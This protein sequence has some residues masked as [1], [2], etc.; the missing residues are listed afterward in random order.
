LLSFAYTHTVI[1]MVSSRKF[2][3]PMIQ[4]LLN[5]VSCSPSLFM[6]EQIRLYDYINNTI[7]TLSADNSPFL[8]ST[9]T[10]VIHGMVHPV[11][12]ATLPKS[13]VLVSGCSP[14]PEIGGKI[15]STPSYLMCKN[16]A[17][18]YVFFHFF[19]PKTNASCFGYGFL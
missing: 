18:L 17:S 12:P 8:L 7:Y 16:H 1:C 6:I 3:L 2:W 4:N 9:I 15:Q 14:G 11:D 5:V 13:S 19:P 10:L